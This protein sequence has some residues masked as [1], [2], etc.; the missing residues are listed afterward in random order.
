MN[1][2]VLFFTKLVR[3]F[4]LARVNRQDHA[5]SYDQMPTPQDN[6]GILIIILTKLG[7]TLFCL[8]AIREIKRS[9]PGSRISVVVTRK[10]TALVEGME[11]VDEILTFKG[12]PSHIPLMMAMKDRTFDISIEIMGTEP[13]APIIAYYS[14]APFRVGPTGKTFSFL[15]NCPYPYPR[16]LY[17]HHHIDDKLKKISFIG[18]T[19]Q[20]RSLNLDHLASHAASDPRL[21][22]KLIRAGVNPDKDYVVVHPGTDEIRRCY[23]PHLFREVIRQLMDHHGI[24]VVVTGIKR[25]RKLIS[26]VIEGLPK[27][28]IRVYN[29]DVLTLTRLLLGARLV[30]SNDTGPLHLAAGLGTNTL[31]LFGPINPLRAAPRLPYFLKG[32]HKSLRHPYMDGISCEDK[33]CVHP[34]CLESIPVKEVIDAANDLLDGDKTE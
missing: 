17:P 30:I 14:G 28:A 24:D 25:E 5:H 2:K 7:D 12:I 8:P 26:K 18:A 1:F 29:S 19:I 31:S 6:P 34:V 22:E 10:Y 3:H 9:F 16:G 27:P 11:E 20:D 13:E 33:S 15:F 4:L 21:E 32:R 23:P